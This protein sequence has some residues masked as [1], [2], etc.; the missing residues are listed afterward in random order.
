MRIALDRF[1]SKLPLPA[2]ARWPSGTWDV[3]AFAH[4][5]M[6]I[7]LFTPRGADH[8]TSHEQDELYVVLTGSGELTIAG[9]AHP[10]AAGDTLFVAANAPHRFTRF[11]EDLVTWAIFWG[12]PGG[13]RSSA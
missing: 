4:G 5:S 13:E 11:T 1:L 7:V 6:S 10:F 12:P 2:T 3:E 9:V 8:Q